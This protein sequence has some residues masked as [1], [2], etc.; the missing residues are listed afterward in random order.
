[1]EGL[2][3]RVRSRLRVSVKLARL[4]LAQ[5][6]FFS[7]IFDCLGPALMNCCRIG[8]LGIVVIGCGSGQGH[9]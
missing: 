8:D 7:D 9:R 3:P 2:E 5:G 1:M 4:V 6:Q